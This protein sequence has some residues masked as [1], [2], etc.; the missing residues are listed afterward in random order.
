V[1]LGCSSAQPVTA[2]EKAKRIAELRRE[3]D[4][5]YA[6]YR[7]S[8]N[9]PA[10]PD[11]A[12]LKRSI[13]CHEETTRIAPDTCPNC[14]ARHA[15]G[16][17]NLGRYYQGRLR[18]LEEELAKAEGGRK[19]QLEAEIAECRS[20]MTSAFARANRQFEN[21]FEMSRG[22]NQPVNPDLYLPVMINCEF[23]KDYAKALYYLD[24]YAATVDLNDEGKKKADGLRAEW[25]SELRRAEEEKLREELTAKPQ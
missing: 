11:L 16:L 15:E 3:A 25:T 12:A 2:V 9:D 24:L 21:Y 7:Q 20:A 10:G 1:A 8:V 17:T 22:M 18:P 5:Q 19:A 13:E 14:F 23:V 4:E 6:V